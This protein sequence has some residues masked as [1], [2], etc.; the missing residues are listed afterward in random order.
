MLRIDHSKCTLCEVCISVCPFSAL[1]R[2]TDEIIVLDSC[3]LCGV[4]VRKC[5][6]A[7][8]CIETKRV[9]LPVSEAK[10]V[11][12]VAEYEDENLHPVTLELVGKDA[13]WLIKSLLN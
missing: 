8:M 6:E 4:C 2:A 11:L 3:R 9:D 7:A 1:Q 5:P 10:N 12:V 13:Q